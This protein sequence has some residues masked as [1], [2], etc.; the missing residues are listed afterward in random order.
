MVLDGIGRT[1]TTTVGKPGDVGPIEQTDILD[2]RDKSLRPGGRRRLWLA[3]VVAI[4]L[5]LVIWR[6]F[7]GD[8]NAATTDAVDAVDQ[9]EQLDQDATVDQIDQDAAG[10]AEEAGD[11]GLDQEADPGS[12]DDASDSD[13]A[14]SAADAAT[15]IDSPVA[16]DFPLFDDGVQRTIA[17]LGVGE[18]R[19]IDATTGGVREVP[20]QLP[21][22]ASFGTDFFNQRG[23]ELLGDRVIVG[24]QG[25]VVGVPVGAGSSIDFGRSAAFYVDGVGDDQRLVI[26]RQVEEDPVGDNGEFAPDFEAQ[27]YTA[28]GVSVGDPVDLPE[29]PSLFSFDGV[30][31]G[32]VGTYRLLDDGF[33]RL[34]TGYVV[35][36]GDN[37]ALVQE[38]DEGLDC[39][40]VLIDFAT[41]ERSTI[42]DLPDDLPFDGFSESLI[43][44]DGRWLVTNGGFGRLLEIATGEVFELGPD[45]R[46]VQPLTFTPDGAYAVAVRSQG[47]LVLNLQTGE[48]RSVPSDDLG[49]IDDRSVAIIFESRS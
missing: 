27:L 11:T 2:S 6:M 20:V 17:V 43:S 38:C 12:G 28:D 36:A 39:N 40:R 29:Y 49:S 31:S 9:E 8:D 16:G 37:H 42:A 48:S 10:D 1:G 46:F 15:P 3:A 34:S 33:D 18:I 5:G 25:T 13:E 30:M 14:E 7:P 24:R 26:V 21:E 44:P 45:S 41:G 4:L 23:I 32:L 19:F 22:S 35:A 47:L